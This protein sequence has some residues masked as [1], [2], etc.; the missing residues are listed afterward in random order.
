MD[1]VSMLNTMSFYCQPILPLV[2]DESMSYYETLCKVVGQLNTTGET[3][4]KLNEGLTGEIADRQKADSLLNERLKVVEA[5]NKKT[6]FLTFAGTPPHSARPIGTMPTRS[7]LHQWVNDGDMIVTLLET[8][9]EGRKLVYAASC[10][11]NAGNWADE[12]SE[13][14]NIIVPI[15]TAYDSDGDYAVR[16]KIAKITIPPAS[17][18]SLEDEWALQVIEINTPSTA[19]NGVVNFS[20]N[21]SE[22]GSVNCNLTPFEFMQL[23][24]P[25][26]ANKNLCVAVNAK[27]VSD[28]Y[29]RTSSIA[30][31]NPTNHLIRIAFERDYGVAITNGV[32]QLNKTLDYIIGN[33]SQNTWTH[34]SIDSK[35]FDFPRYEGFQF[36]RGAHNVITTDDES[37]PNAVYAH[38]HANASGKLYQ[39]LPTRL[40]DTVDGAEYW[41]GTF[42][43]YG[44]NHMTF[45]FV[46]SNYATASDKMLV[47]VIELSADVNTTTWKYG[48]KEF[49]LPITGSFT[50]D[51]A[52]SATSTNPV[53]NKVVT[54]ALAG[55]ASTALASET[56]DGLMSAADKTKLIGIQNGATKTI[57]DDALLATSANPVQNKVV[58]AALDSKASTAVATQTENGLMSAKDKTKLDGVADGANKTT[59]IDALDPNS[60]NPVSSAALFEA[61]SKKADRTEATEHAAG[62]MSATDKRKLNGIEDGA[63]KTIVD[64]MLSDGSTNP[65]QNKAVTAAL[66]AVVRDTIYPIAVTATSTEWAVNNGIAYKEASA[67]R[68]FDNIKAAYNGNK[69]PV[70][71]FE[72]MTYSL[73]LT[74]S[75]AFVFAS[76][77]GAVAN[78]TQYTGLGKYP[79]SLITI[80][81]TGV[82]ISRTAGDLPAVDGTDNG[83]MLIVV[84]G[85]WAS[86]RVPGTT[87][88]TE[89]S[90]TSENPVQNKT[91]TEA[92]N[93][94]LPK[95][96]GTVTGALRT[97]DSFS[98]GGTIAFGEAPIGLSQT[99]DGAAEIRSGS[100]DV[101]DNPPPLARLKVADPTEDNDAATKK[102]VVGR[103][104]SPQFKGY[105]TLTPADEQ[106]GIGVGLSP[107]RDGN[108]FELNISDVNEQKPTKLTG[109]KTPTDTDNNAAAT[110]EYVKAKVA[111]GGSSDFVINGTVNSDMAVTLDKTFEEIQ[112]A[113]NAGKRAIL[114]VALGGNSYLVL[115]PFSVGTT[116]I[117]FTQVL[118]DDQY[119]GG[120]AVVVGNN[121]ATVK[122]VS[123]PALT[124]AG[125]MAQLSMASGPAEDMQIATKQYVDN[126]VVTTP[127]VLTYANNQATGA[128]YSDIRKAIESGRQIKLAVANQDDIIASNAKNETDRSLLQFTH[129]GVGGDTVDFT[130]YNVTAQASG[131]TVNVK[132]IQLP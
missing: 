85:E 44:D 53:Q 35:V 117:V 77:R 124:A 33:V 8:S 108:N 26:W 103:N 3:V 19:A 95:T 45:T 92:L 130:Q 10:S 106:L 69:T 115:Y 34:E 75:T 14:F 15:S 17:V 12:S 87:V 62:L 68:T 28:G 105:V 36:T 97:N 40:I 72:G 116:Q 1:T 21:I 24:A 13:D 113:I 52:L 18:S 46:T 29:T 94:K 128:S 73:I 102:Y 60:H 55:K 70:C 91:V 41:N 96:G 98:A 30:T 104:I 64:E 100:A 38:Y 49:E 122:A 9:E 6:H 54:G 4:N 121:G 57:V 126:A 80:N 127:L 16:Q 65:V 90:T 50:V 132:S 42:D 27:L 25:T 22:D 86:Q 112:E 119:M 67:D 110:V 93:S 2:Y 11:Y 61:L 23:Y 58:K 89:L 114:E 59:V 88:D 101:D 63:N 84:N 66:A 82:V 5:T 109:V 111:S 51:D 83:K 43:M 123:A 125:S 74:S 20:A 76:Y 81:T 47:R 131:I 56:A 107:S 79:T 118:V 78:D 120:R 71:E 48:V 31:L 32:S 7:E 37:T 39:N 129:T 99:A